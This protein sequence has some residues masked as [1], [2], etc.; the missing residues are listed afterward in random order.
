M[1]PYVIGGPPADRGRLG[2]PFRIGHITE[3]GGVRAR[4]LWSLSM[5]PALPSASRSAIG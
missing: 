1:F 2:H 3:D 5:N 4:L